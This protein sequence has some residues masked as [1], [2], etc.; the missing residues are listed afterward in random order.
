MSSD[1]ILTIGFLY[2]QITQ[3][4][5]KDSCF[6]FP[7]GFNQLFG[8]SLTDSFHALEAPEKRGLGDIAYTLNRIQNGSD[9]SF[10]PFIA[11]E[12]NGKTVHLILNMR[13]QMEQG[14]VRLHADDGRRISIK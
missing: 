8:R 11:M 3:A 9:L 12:C 10:A 4:F 2:G 5:L 7:Y 13:K 1:L 14:T 6:S